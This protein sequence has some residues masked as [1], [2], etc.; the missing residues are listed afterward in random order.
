MK[1]CSKCKV[2]R[3][4][5]AFH[6]HSGKKDGL[7]SHCKNCRKVY[8]SE[9][10][11]AL[12]E[13][14]R[15]HYWANKER[16]SEKNKAYCEANRESVAKNKK[17]WYAANR[18]LCHERCKEYRKKRLRTDHAFRCRYLASR[19]IHQALSRGGHTKGG[20][21]FDHLPYTPAELSEH[22][23]ST[24]QDG[25]TEADFLSGALHI[26]HIFPQSL[27]PYDSLTHPNFQK[28][29]ALSNLRLITA[30]HNIAKGNKI[31]IV[32]DDGTL[33]FIS[34]EQYLTLQDD[35]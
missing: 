9:N 19:L 22:L 30:E 27:T 8:S 17:K 3:G 28:A 12:A 34:Y 18:G 16:A 23:P 4:C 24:L 35:E 14:S 5:S 21:T 32:D 26:D 6:K 10:K 7:T 13:Y 25:Y 31:E 11:E 29:W 20:R 2:E 33:S 15:S 1:T